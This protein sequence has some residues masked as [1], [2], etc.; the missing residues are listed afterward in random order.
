MIEMFGK[1]ALKCIN[2]EL[3]R[4]GGGRSKVT[5]FVVYSLGHSAAL[6]AYHRFYDSKAESHST[7]IMLNKLQINCC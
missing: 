2:N 5:G 4:A 3:W 1:N 7:P 6:Q